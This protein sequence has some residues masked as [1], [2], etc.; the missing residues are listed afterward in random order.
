MEVKSLKNKR[1]AEKSNELWTTHPLYRL[2]KKSLRKSLCTPIKV[3]G[4]ILPWDRRVAEGAQSDYKLITSS[5]LE[6]FLVTDEYWTEVIKNFSWM[7]VRL[8][9]DLNIQNMTLIP[10]EIDLDG[11]N[12]QQAE[13]IPIKRKKKSKVGHLTLLNGILTMTPAVGTY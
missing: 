3:R 5:G 11:P 12:E 6:Y 10:R 8:K 7:T 1:G 9:G 2:N 4:T 13:V